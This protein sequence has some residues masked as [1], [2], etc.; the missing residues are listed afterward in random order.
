MEVSDGALAAEG[1]RPHPLDGVAVTAATGLFGEGLAPELVAHGDSRIY[2]V[3]R[4][5]DFVLRLHVPLEVAVD[6]PPRQASFL[7]SECLWLAALTA[8]T[9][10]VVPRPVIAGTD[11][12]FVGHAQSD[13]GEQ[14]AF[15]V[16]EWIEGEPIGGPL[17][18]AFAYRLGE[19]I[20]TLHGHGHSWT[21][22]PGFEV[23]VHDRRAWPKLHERFE[24]LV[25]AGTLAAEDVE[26]L[27]RFTDRVEEQPLASAADAIGLIH[28]D[29]HDGNLL[30]TDSG[31]AILDF[32]RIGV[33]PWLYDL[34][35]GLQMFGPAVRRS[36][37]DAYAQTFP[38]DADDVRVLEEH[39]VGA[40]VETLAHHAPNP[41]EHEY[42][43][44]ALPIAREFA[45]L[46]LDDRPFLFGK[47]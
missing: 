3:H 35:Q 22:P 38:V 17:D 1:S 9:D 33:G 27:R 7:E 46:Y 31:I 11:G 24:S 30:Q 26:R 2:R 47:E 25:E 10:L 4:E 36:C 28:G 15:T 39:F 5:A 29:L 6:E 12:Q 42:L 23:P 13:G 34:A 16:L 40:L 37:V 44:R 14:I 18:E 32:G 20:A 43:R 21:R 19:Q 41:D 45:D 8:D